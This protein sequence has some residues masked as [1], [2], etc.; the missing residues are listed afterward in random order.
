[1]NRML[2]PT[3][4]RPVY[5]LIKC[6]SG[7]YDQIFISVRQLR[8]CW[9]GVL[10]LTRGRVCRLQLLLNLASAVIL[11]SKSLGIRDHIL[12][13][14]IRD[15]SFRHLLRVAGLRWR[16]STPPLHGIL[17]NHKKVPSVSDSHRSVLVITVRRPWWQTPPRSVSLS[18]F[19][20]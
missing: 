9:C 11:G 15:F 17:R 16:C 2:R 14:Q 5:L 1:V 8:I 13:S 4:S 7:P 18:V 12:L 6:P 19:L 3:V 10:S 20:F